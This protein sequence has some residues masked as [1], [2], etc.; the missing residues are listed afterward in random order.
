MLRLEY[1]DMVIEDGQKEGE[2]NIPI[3][4]ESDV[5]CCCAFG[6]VCPMTIP[7]EI[8][9]WPFFLEPKKK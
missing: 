2:A 5:Q 1:V 7:G 8:R 9:Q 6:G 3:S 4:E